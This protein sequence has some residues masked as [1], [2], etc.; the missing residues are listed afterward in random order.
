MIEKGLRP[1]SYVFNQ[2]SETVNGVN[3][4]IPVYMGIGVDAPS[5]NSVQAKCTPEIVYE[6]VINSFNAGAS[7][8]IYSPNYNFMKF[9]NLDGSVK[10]LNELK[11]L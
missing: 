4:E 3:N 11:L 6:S 7:G 9:S 5:Y 10:A 8:V 1:D 2:C